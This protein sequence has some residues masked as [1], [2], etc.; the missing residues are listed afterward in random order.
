M[1]ERL[2]KTEELKDETLYRRVKASSERLQGISLLKFS[3]EN[4]GFKE[5]PRIIDSSVESVNIRTVFPLSLCRRISK[6]RPIGSHVIRKMLFIFDLCIFHFLCELLRRW[7]DAK[8][9]TK[10]VGRFQK[11]GPSVVTLLEKCYLSLIFVFFIL[12]WSSS[13]LIRCQNLYKTCRK[14]SKN[15]PISSHV[16]RKMLFIFDLCIFYFTVNFFDSML[17]FVQNVFV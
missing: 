17:K 14:I 10:G 13:S 8:I 6:N 11:I 7:F 1:T 15:R 3:E 2:K 5:T 4:R 12:L 16:I 9:C